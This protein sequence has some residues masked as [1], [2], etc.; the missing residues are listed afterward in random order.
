MRNLLQ[1]PKFDPT[2][3]KNLILWNEN[4][5]PA[6]IRSLFELPEDITAKNV[7]E[8]LKTTLKLLEEK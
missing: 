1:N 3:L 7:I 2:M 6:D 8:T 5:I 4:Q